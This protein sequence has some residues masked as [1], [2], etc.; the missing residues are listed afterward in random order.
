M[1]HRHFVP[2][3]PFDAFIA[4]IW[5]WE[6]DPAAHRREA[7]T[8]SCNMGL[9]VD[10]SRDAL[11]YYRGENYSEHTRIAPI[12]IHG[13]HAEPFAI[14]AYQPRIMGVEFKPGG[15]YPFFGPAA[16][17]FLDAHI[18]LEF[19]WGAAARRLY[20]RLVQAPTPEDKARILLGA[21]AK[22]APRDLA[23]HPAVLLALQAFDRAPHRTSVG[24][25]AK[26]A[27]LSTKTFIRVFSDQVGLTPKLYLRVARFQRVIERILLVPQ[28]DWW[29]VVERHGYYDQP[30][31]IRDFRNF[32]GF[33]PTMWQKLRGPQAHHIPLPE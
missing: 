8:A 20:D 27:E 9:L 31:F 28:I 29:D 13:A 32:T 16:L 17:E 33:T 15:A 26:T 19:V 30:H 1:L 5:Y 12:A 10:L 14:D 11:G 23:L 18:P 24:A 6:G 3:P 2:P 25:V 7:I 21:L 22:A 4:G